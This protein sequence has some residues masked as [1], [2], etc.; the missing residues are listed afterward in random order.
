MA[1]FVENNVTSIEDLFIQLESFGDKWVY[2]GQ[3]SD[4]SLET[5]FE[6]ACHNSALVLEHD[7]AKVEEEM[8]RQFKRWYSGEDRND[9]V[10]D[11]LYCLSLMR[12]YGS[13]SR[14]LDATYSSVVAAYFALESAIKHQTI[15]GRKGCSVWCING[16]WLDKEAR[17]IAGNRIIDSRGFDE[18]RRDDSIFYELYMKGHNK[19]VL[20]EN[21]LRLHQR[22]YIQQGVFLC[23]GD[24]SITFVDNLKSM[25]D[26]ENPQNIVKV[27]C[28]TTPE[29][30]VNGLEKLFK[31]NISRASLFPGL[32]G[33][34][35]SLEFRL[36]FFNKL[37][38][39]RHLPTRE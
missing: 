23:P 28:K 20:T 30:I 12:H 1:D 11:T 8:I 7:A 3:Y 5:S 38:A 16:N 4:F 14:L 36:P 39:L 32:D 27:T 37:Y 15:N 34:A 22:L 25:G 18:E 13:P 24:V 10:E 35:Q 19:L 33:Y 2:R 29:D 6:R 9:V 26:W 17:K 31:M 21:P